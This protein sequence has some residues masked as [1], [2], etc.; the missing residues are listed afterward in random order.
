[1]VICRTKLS[2]PSN[3]VRWLVKL[4][5]T[6]FDFSN[7]NLGLLGCIEKS[8]LSNVPLAVAEMNTFANLHQ[9][10][11]DQKGILAPYVINHILK[12]ASNLIFQ[13]N[14]FTN[15]STLGKKFNIEYI[16]P[17][18]FKALQRTE[19][20][21]FSLAAE[22]NNTDFKYYLK[23]EVDFIYCDLQVNAL[24]AVKSYERLMVKFNLP[25]KSDFQLKTLRLDIISF[26]NREKRKKNL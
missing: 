24:R 12:T 20:L 17:E 1:M 2:R 9:L 3:K 6:S 16:I 26:Y 5:F 15:Y 7:Q 25:I 8:Y 14:D 21:I 19:D 11:F 22:L 13:L 4:R 23:D 10:P 18:V